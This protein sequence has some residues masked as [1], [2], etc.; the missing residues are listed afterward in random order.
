M[1]RN[2]VLQLR[3]NEAEWQAINAYL[4]EYAIPNRARWV[5]E[6]LISEVLRQ[7]SQ[8]T[9]LPFAR[10]DEFLEEGLFASIEEEPVPYTDLRFEESN[11][12]DEC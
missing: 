6:T 11:L 5:R 1:P 10:D 12:F 8:K 4:E 9:V 2:R 7:I 3:L